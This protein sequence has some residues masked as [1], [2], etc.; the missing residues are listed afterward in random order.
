M[1]LFSCQLKA[2][3]RINQAQLLIT[4]Y[5]HTTQDYL[6]TAYQLI[7][8]TTSRFSQTSTLNHFAAA[9]L[10]VNDINQSQISSGSTSLNS[11]PQEIIRSPTWFS[12]IKEDFPRLLHY[13]VPLITIIL[14][15]Q[16]LYRRAIVVSQHRLE[17]EVAQR[18]Q[19]LKIENLRLYTMS[20]TDSLTGIRNRHFIEEIISQDLNRVDHIYETIQKND[21]QPDK[22]DLLAI[23]IDIDHFKQINDTYGHLAGDQVLAQVGHRL[24]TLFRNYDYVVRWGGEEFLVVARFVDRKQLNILT[25]K[26]RHA[27]ESMEIDLKQHGQINITVSIGAA[28]YPFSISQP[29]IISWDQVIYL[30]DMALY[31]AKHSSRNSWFSY[32]GNEALVIPE[33]FQ[34]NHKNVHQ[35]AQISSKST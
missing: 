17:Q 34:L 26:V 10:S 22:A 31:Q 11:S 4:P 3:I 14:V 29:S 6:T 33:S 24:M 5:H 35:I 8:T 7:A 23:I 16:L 12:D 9:Q 32:M 28:P 20:Q 13:F 27:M 18:T 15:L 21:Q 19:A 25:E 1:L 30:A 2:N